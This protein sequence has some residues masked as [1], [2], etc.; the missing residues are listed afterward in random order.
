MKWNFEIF[1]GRNVKKTV[2]KEFGLVEKT[3][4]SVKKLTKVLSEHEL[5]NVLE[6]L[7]NLD[8]VRKVAK[9]VLRATVVKD[10]VKDETEMLLVEPTQKEQKEEKEKENMAQEKINDAGIPILDG[11]KYA[12]WELKLFNTLE[13]RD[14]KDPAVI[15]TNKGNITD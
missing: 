8:E 14:C 6:E 9:L 13:F 10:T 11:A 1:P 2:K 4:E 5:K 15:A 12:S 7:I 3:P